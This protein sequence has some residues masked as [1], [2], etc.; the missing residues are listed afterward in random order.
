[1]RPNKN[2]SD[3]Y[4]L[5]AKLVASTSF[6]YLESYYCSMVRALDLVFSG[7]KGFLDSQFDKQTW[8]QSSLP[9]F[10][11]RNALINVDSHL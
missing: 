9:M 1:M 11:Y 8:E 5:L 10:Y 2:T 6:V 7:N 4:N 3:L